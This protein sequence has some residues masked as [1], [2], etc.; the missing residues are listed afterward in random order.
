MP[1]DDD[2]TG[3]K[4][5]IRPRR[6]SSQ[7]ESSLK[8]DGLDLRS[9]AKP[10]WA[11]G[12][13]QMDRKSMGLNLRFYSFSYLDVALEVCSQQP[14]TKR[15]LQTPP[16]PSLSLSQSQ[17]PNP[18]YTKLHHLL[19]QSTIEEQQRATV[20]GELRA[21]NNHHIHTTTR[22]FPGW[23]FEL[24]VVARKILGSLPMEKGKAS[25]LFVNDGSFMEKF[26]QLEQE[27]GPALGESKPGQTVS[28]TS[29]PKPI[30]SKTSFESKA[31]DF[32]KTT[33]V[34]SSGKLAFSL[35]Q[36][37]KLVAPSVKL[38]EDEDEEESVAGNALGNEPAKRQRL[39]Q[40]DASEQSSKQ[41]DV[42][43]P[44][45]SDP[46]VKKVADKLASFVAKNG[47]QFE[48]IT[49]K[50]NPGDT[51]FKFLFDEN[52]ADYK[53]Y[54][55]RLSEEEKAL[56]RARD[57]QTS[58]SGGISTAALSPTSGPQRSLQQH[59]NYQTPASALYEAIEDTRASMTSVQTT[60]AGRSG[61][62]TLSF[63]NLDW[64]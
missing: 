29:I 6:P 60:S 7:A 34:A 2:A 57:S 63:S 12:E 25:S 58:Q 49:R 61:Y 3:W 1:L 23:G 39:G 38:S 52:C 62:V 42:A 46:T 17:I 11:A 20:Y 36:K 33:P 19:H 48:H 44:P 40:P 26:K 13:F 9:R 54:Y 24:G 47:R 18:Y 30:I 56:L 14:Q 15:T 59:S 8:T 41:V 32:R 22:D 31:N 28:G 27:K 51:P 37:S 4:R 45:P 50:K 21:T 10:H 43:P 55:Y 64:P 53:Y 16:P 35:K 5:D